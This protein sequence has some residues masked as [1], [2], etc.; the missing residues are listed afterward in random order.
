MQYRSC[1]YCYMFNLSDQLWKNQPKLMSR[2]VLRNFFLRTEQYLRTSKLSAFTIIVHG[3]EPLLAGHDFFLELGR[4]KKRMVDA[5][6][7][8]LTLVMQTNSLLFR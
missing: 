2:Q 4:L 8:E 6:G 5:T 3:G 1:K 7:V